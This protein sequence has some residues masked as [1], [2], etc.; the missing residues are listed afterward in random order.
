MLLRSV[1]SIVLKRAVFKADP[2]IARLRP[3]PDS[4][5]GFAFYEYFRGR[6]AR[7]R[8]LAPCHIAYICTA[9]YSTFGLAFPLS[10]LIASFKNQI[11]SKATHGPVRWPHESEKFVGPTG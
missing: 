5:A 4:V 2:W 11:V 7:I 8:S 10:F 6:E 9:V 1:L 3:H